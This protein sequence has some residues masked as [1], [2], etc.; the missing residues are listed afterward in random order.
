MDQAKPF[1]HGHHRFKHGKDHC[2]WSIAEQVRTPRGWGQRHRLYLGE[3]NDRQK[4]VWTNVTG[5]FDPVG[6]QTRELALNPADRAVPEPAAHSGGPVRLAEF[7][8]RRPRQWGACWAG[9]RRWDQ[10]H[11][12]AFWRARLPDSREGTGWRQVLDP[13]P[14]CRLID[15]GSEVGRHRQWVQNRARADLLGADFGLAQK[16]NWHRGRDKVLAHRPAL[17]PHLR[18][19]WQDLFGAKVAVRL[20]DLTRPVR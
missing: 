19:R 13:L 9:C 4:A 2:Y 6:Q 5:V 1:L 8:L 3:I 20:Y 18:Q 16:D 12:D 14:S 17:F 10:L 7:G 15:P 11:L